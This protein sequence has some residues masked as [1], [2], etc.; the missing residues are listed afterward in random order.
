MPHDF[1]KMMEEK[2]CHFKAE[3]GAILEKDNER[4]F[5]QEKMEK[6]EGNT[7]QK[8]LHRVSTIVLI[9]IFASAE[10][11]TL[12]NHFSSSEEMIDLAELNDIKRSVSTGPDHEFSKIKSELTDTLNMEITNLTNR[13]ESGIVHSQIMICN[14]SGVKCPSDNIY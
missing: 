14:F 8:N 9:I 1:T 5:V 10:L 13:I 6:I 4:I 2:F 7:I 3:I 12:K 11:E